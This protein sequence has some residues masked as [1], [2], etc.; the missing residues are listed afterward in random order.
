ME[1]SVGEKDPKTGHITFV[2]EYLIEMTEFE[3]KAK[4][5]DLEIVESLNFTEVYHKYKDQYYD[6]LKRMMKV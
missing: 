5:F 2:P 6:L 4:E 3:R 1:D